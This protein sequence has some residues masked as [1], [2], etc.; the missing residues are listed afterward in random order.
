M[1]SRRFFYPSTKYDRC[2]LN[3]RCV[4]WDCR[5]IIPWGNGSTFRARL[6]RRPQSGMSVSG[7][8]QLIA[9]A[10]DRSLRA[11]GAVKMKTGLGGV[12]AIQAADQDKWMTGSHS[13]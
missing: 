11:L 9:W 5:L 8:G 4:V 2:N 12:S 1:G 6:A 7:N 10:G 13:F 3:S